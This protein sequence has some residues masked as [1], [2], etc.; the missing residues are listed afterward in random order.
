[1]ILKG[2]ENYETKVH[3][4]RRSFARS[5]NLTEPVVFEAAVRKL[6]KNRVLQDQV[7]HDFYNFRD[8]YKRWI[9]A[10]DAEVLLVSMIMY[11]EQHLELGHAQRRVEK[12]VAQL[13]APTHSSQISAGGAATARD[14]GR[15]ARK[16]TVKRLRPFRR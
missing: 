15:M 13:L 11:T 9:T 8:D 7:L 3:L 6:I 1:M 2:Q 12:C 10:H 16:E 14:L 5:I 4:K